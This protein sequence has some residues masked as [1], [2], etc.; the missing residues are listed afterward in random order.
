MNHHSENETWL[1]DCGDCIIEKKAA[2]GEA[3]LTDRERLI[4]CLWIT[5]YMLRNAGDFENAID[6]YPDFKVDAERL[7]QKLS[8]QVTK[9]TFGLSIEQLQQQYFERFESIC[10]EIKAVEYGSIA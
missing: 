10:N 7:A 4:Y 9:E 6:L 3:A 2:H 5:D 8:L 1:I